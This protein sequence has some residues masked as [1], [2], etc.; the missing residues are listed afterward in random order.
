MKIYYH[1]NLLTL[2]ENDFIHAAF[3]SSNV[4]ADTYHD[5]NFR[6]NNYNHAMLSPGKA[7]HF[8]AYITWDR[9]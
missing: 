4:P 3:L 7:Y 8:L 9:I 2:D 6:K 1:F 5:S